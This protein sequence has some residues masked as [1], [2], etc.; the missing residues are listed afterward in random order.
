MANNITKIDQIHNV[1]PSHYNTRVNP[2]WNALITA[3][4][5]SDQNLANLIV[6][7]K[8]QFFI[9]TASAPYLDN[10]A[11]NDGVSRPAG[12][13]MN[14]STFKQFIP[15]M[16]YQPKQ[17]KLII[18]QLLNIFFAKEST[19]AYV[20]S[21][22]AQPY[23]LEDGWELEYT[24]DG[25]YDELVYF[26]TTD[27]TNIGA[28]LAEE[29][30]ASINRQAEHSSAES[31][32]DNV[33]KSYYV[34]IFTNTVGSKGSIQMVGGRADIALQ[35]NGFI[36][37]A[38]NGADTEWT[39][40]KIGDQV[41]F[42][43]VG[44]ISPGINQ[45]QVGNVIIS[46]LPGNVGYFPITNID[47]SNN[48][49][50]FTNL[51][52]TP[53]TYTQTSV[54]Q[55]KFFVANKYVAF[56]QDVRAMTWEVTPGEVIVELPATP[57]VVKRSLIGAAHINGS[58]STVTATNSETSITVVDASQFPMSG[59]F[60][61][62][63]TEE[64]ITRYITPT[65][66]VISTNTFN[67]RFQGRPI[68]Y[69]YANRLV[70]ETSGNTTAGSNI[71]TNLI[72]LAG[73][74]IG[75]NVFMVGVPSYALITDIDIPNSTVTVD[76]PATA[77]GN[78][79]I[80]QFA[81]NTLNDITPSLPPLAI[82][83]EN[84]LTSLVRSGNVVTATTSAP[85]GYQVG[86]TV[87]IYN[88]TGILS[89]SATGTIAEGQI[90]ITGVTPVATVAAGELVV[91]ANILT[92]TL[93]QDV[94]GST[95]VMTQNA[96]GSGTEAITFNENL[97]GAF[98]ITSVTSNTFTYD[99]IGL[100][101][102]ASTAGTSRVDTIGMAPTGSL[103]VITAA[104]P[105]SFTR[106]T[107]PY[108]WDL[109][110]P[111]VLSDNIAT[112]TES[113]QAGQTIPL[114]SLSANT[115]PAAGGFVVF[116]YGLNTQEGPVQYLYTPNDTTI[117]ID[118]SYVFQYDHAIGSNIIS[119]DN[120]GPHIMSGLGTEYPP[121]ITNPSDV[122]VTLENLITSV[123]SAG[124]FIDFLVRYPDQLYSVLPTYT[125]T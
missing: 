29:I 5:Q 26:H 64:I 30:A 14:D 76:Y 70:L 60:W 109:S 43:Y 51:F 25:I 114:L 83:N 24:V 13:G 72:S 32:Y 111:F 16:A 31:Y 80:A 20:E 54:T 97:N 124:I 103:V 18:D 104:L 84:V 59:T 69:T 58:E 39:V 120:K 112:L 118:P 46:L 57:P 28:A 85:H 77:D 44:G 79:V 61:L 81:G 35:F 86:D 125:V 101:G 38:G 89:T 21:G 92:G 27:F 63:E 45:L 67:T 9:K 48:S 116:D 95:V 68:E 93:V 108:V 106:I 19:T 91:G 74:E 50:T 17:V 33:S 88:S 90:D 8:D 6:A 65:E 1:M 107:G 96:T 53:G 121:Y 100:N 73:L 56:T 4:G 15:I 12:T 7:I 66:N 75:Q 37:T 119:I 41:T 117:V 2:N 113:I 3:I 78:G 105:V 55:T 22:Q 47:L 87:S 52:G 23:V 49:F 98:I 11:A 42:Q 82:L 36:T 34:K 10:L 71:I 122:R 123:A 40:T 99:S 94:I 115:I 102:T 110:A 62:Q